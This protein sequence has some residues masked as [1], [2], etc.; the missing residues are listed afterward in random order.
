MILN[1]KL[2]AALGLSVLLSSGTAL[3]QEQPHV[4]RG[5]KIIPVVG[6]PIENGVLVVQNG[7]ITAVGAADKVRIPK[8]AQE[9]DMTGKVLMPGLVDTHSHL[10]EGSGGDGSAALHP[11]VQI[12]DGINPISDTFKRALA[13][14]ITTVNVMPGSGHLMSG[15][16][17][18]LKMR[19]G[20][21]ISDLTFCDD[22]INGICG[23]MKMANGTNP[24]R[25]APFPGTRAKSAAMAR[26]L[27]LDAQAYNQKI[28]AAKGKADKMPERKPNL[29]PL[30]EILEG[31]RIVHFHT[32]RYDDILT[33][34]RLKEEF[35]FKLVLHHVS[36]AWKAADE[37]AKAGV[38]A[39]I[40][41]LD[42][43]GGKSEAVELSNTNGAALEK[44]GVLTA[45]HTDDGI[46]DSRLFMRN[47]ALAVRAGMSREKAIEG[48]TIAGA[49]MLELDG[50]VG[51]LEKGKDADFI[52]LSGE[53]FSVYTKIE[54]TWVEGQKRFDL[55]NPEDKAYA[56]GGFR[57]YDGILHYHAH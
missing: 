37:I 1:Q 39:S 45:F 50:R 32:H 36:E 54:Q 43:P 3:A 55:A 26:Q 11:D 7:K 48:L 14:G 27:F 30:V 41:T 40:I 23:G 46:T 20:N 25:P 28:K 38:P 31:K 12:I 6:Q 22:V 57:A 8:N 42:S 2:L 44:A 29:E 18:Y 19:E 34:L 24:M 33:A 53:P 21:T 15:Q 35:G 17:V 5:A 13:G 56:T 4:F 49:K 10:G 51:S 47:V 16:T 52:V 9:F